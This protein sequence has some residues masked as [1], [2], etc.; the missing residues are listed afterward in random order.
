MELD[1]YCKELKLAFEHHGTQHYKLSRFCNSTEQLKI[2]QQ[3]DI[4][5]EQICKENGIDLIIIPELTIQTKI[6]SHIKS[7]L[8]ADF[9]DIKIDFKKVFT[10]RSI[11]L[12]KE[13]EIIVKNRDGKLIS[14]GYLG[15]DAPL[16]VFCNKHKKSWFSTPRRIKNGAWCHIC[17]G[18]LHSEDWLKELADK[19]GGICISLSIP[20]FKYKNGKIKVTWKCN[21][22]EH[23]SFDMTPA[24]VY[25]GRWCPP[26]G[27]AKGVKKRSKKYGKSKFSNISS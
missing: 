20:G 13:L 1:G 19:N 2:R 26:C 11:K 23:L 3:D 17:Q 10:P 25:A 24:N 7:S 12:F 18:I 21:N 27:W 8:P 4:V 16:E 6:R 14:E 9:R 15:C 5:K 22:K